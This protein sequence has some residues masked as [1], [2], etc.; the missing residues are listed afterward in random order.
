VENPDEK[1]LTG[2]IALDMIGAVLLAAALGIVTAFLLASVTLLFVSQAEAA[3]TPQQGTLLLRPRASEGDPLSA[4]L[5][6]TAV[7][8]RVSGRVARAKVIQTFRNPGSGWHDGIYVFPLPQDAA[9]DHLRLRVGKRRIEG[10]IAEWPKLVAARVM[11]IEPHALIVVALE[12]E[13]RLRGRD[14][15]AQHHMVWACATD[16]LKN[17]GGER[18]DRC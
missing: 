3:E 15:S 2:K 11:R 6:S 9:V 12:Y 14:G 10:E 4:P 16:G 7:A 5:L 13:V 1:S 8:Y 18:A 17:R